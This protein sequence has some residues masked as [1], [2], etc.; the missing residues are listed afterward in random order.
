[1]LVLQDFL[2]LA[3]TCDSCAACSAGQPGAGAKEPDAGALAARLQEVAA[4]QGE[5]TVELPA[6]FFS[7]P[8]VCLPH[9]L[10][11]RAQLAALWVCCLDIL[12]L[13]RYCF[14]CH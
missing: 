2:P 9:S 12:P 10:E 4:A 6:D 1:M 7:S 8:Q 3:A 13:Q 5:L 14:Y 11:H